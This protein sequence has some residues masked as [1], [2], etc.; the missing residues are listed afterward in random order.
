[1]LELVEAESLDGLMKSTV[2]SH[3]WIDSEE[4]AE[5]LMP[6]E[7]I[8]SESIML[9]HLRN[10]SRK[11]EIYKCYIGNGYHPN[12]C[13]NVI[14][15]NVVENPAWLTAYTP[16]QAEISQGRLEALLNYQTLVT[17]LSGLEVANASLLDEGTAAAEAMTMSFNICNGKK[18]NFLVSHGVFHHTVDIMRTRA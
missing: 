10:L 17:E 14:L 13:P 8:H 2:P 11:N 18:N 5:K 12:L 4:K 6:I 9:K 15:R 3:I 16:Y 7:Y 1:M